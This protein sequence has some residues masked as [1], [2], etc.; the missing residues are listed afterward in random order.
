M[1]EETLIFKA[2]LRALLRQLKQLKKKC[3][4]TICRKLR[5]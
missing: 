4:I 5:S 1:S 2:Y 3:A